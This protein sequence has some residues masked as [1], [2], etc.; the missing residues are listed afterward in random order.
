MYDAYI[1][2]RTQIYLDETQAAELAHRSIARGVTASH[3]IREAVE[4]YLADADDEAA[5]LARQRSA[6]RDAY[7]AI[8]RLP[9]GVTYVDEVRQ[10]DRA[11]DER[12]EERW[13][14]R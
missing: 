11:R 10:G 5:E 14:S 1:V 3:M 7:G 8:P 13:H 9:E 12:L 4:L 6:L 2:K